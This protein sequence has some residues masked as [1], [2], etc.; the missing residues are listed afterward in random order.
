MTSTIRAL[1]FLGVL[2]MPS[3]KQQE[4]PFTA[5][6]TAKNTCWEPQNYLRYEN[7]RTL[8]CTTFYK[9]GT[10]QAFQYTEEGLKPSI[11]IDGNWS[12]NW[13]FSS[14]KQV[15]AF[16]EGEPEHSFTVTRYNH[17]T[18][19]FRD[20]TGHRRIMVRR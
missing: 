14:S 11:Q 16:V 20:H 15:L 19:F 13:S 8:G 1:C 3:C 4:S 6:L 18:I 12:N 9:D 7:E 10:I 2:L 5:L 17:D